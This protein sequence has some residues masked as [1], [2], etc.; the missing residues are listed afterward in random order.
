MNES[1]I[2]FETRHCAKRCLLD[3]QSH[4]F[5]IEGQTRL[6]EELANMQLSELAA[7]GTHGAVVGLEGVTGSGPDGAGEGPS[8]NDLSG[9]EFHTVRRELVG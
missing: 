2:H 6:A 8:E 3:T 4:R 7:D 1:L 9:F 5:V